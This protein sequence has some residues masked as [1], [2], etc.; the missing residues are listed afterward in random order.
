M[1]TDQSK[2]LEALL[3][4]VTG[5]LVLYFVFD[6]KIL[7][8]VALAV[9]LISILIKPLAYLLARAW[10]KLGDLLGWIVSKAVL[11]VMFY[12]LL[13]PLALLHNLFN[14][15]AMQLKNTSKSMWKLR[16]HNY[17]ENDFKNT[18]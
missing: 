18:W 1:K 4:I 3:V 6:T 5:F 17:T 11:S 2:N 15:N 10:F 7:L 13:V 16:E 9:G 8:Y 14:K 12:V